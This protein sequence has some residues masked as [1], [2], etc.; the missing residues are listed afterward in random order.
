MLQEKARQL[1]ASFEEGWQAIKTGSRAISPPL[2]PLPI[3]EL[4]KFEPQTIYD[5]ERA[6]QQLML[7]YSRLQ[8]MEAKMQARARAEIVAARLQQLHNVESL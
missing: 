4:L 1:L 2:E 8:D 3:Q 6:A 5:H 7:H